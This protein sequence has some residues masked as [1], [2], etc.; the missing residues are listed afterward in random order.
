MTCHHCCDAN[1]FFDQKL[2]KKE[3]K[4]YLKK[5]PRGATKRIVNFLDK[6]EINDKSLLD[7]G[8]G[9]GVLQWQ[10]LKK[11]GAKTIDVDAASGYMETARK[12][13]KTKGWEQKA[14]FIEGDFNDIA[15]ELAQ[16]DIV[17]LDKV[18]CCYPDY[19]L[20]LDNA[21]EKAKDYIILSYPLSNWM[22]RV[23]N[24]VG[25]LYFYFKKS[26]FKTYIHPSAKIQGLLSSKGFIIEHRSIKFPWQIQVYRRTE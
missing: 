25:R 7:I 13:A 10:F 17:T 12:Y 9:I 14:S 18:V 11:G 20:I 8:G 23:V 3:L 16:C 21:S 1:K 4:K 24:A 6:L 22:S 2:A 5:G 26:A 19:Q 15:A